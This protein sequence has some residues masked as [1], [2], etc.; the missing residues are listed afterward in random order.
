MATDIA[1]ALG[2][3]K[4]LGERVPAALKL[5][6]LTLA[7]IDDLG[8]IV[9]IAI[10]YSAQ[11]S[12]PALAFG[13][14]ALLVLLALNL[15]SVMRIAPYVVIGIL[16]WVS[17]LKSGVHATLAGVVLALFIPLRASGGSEHSPLREVEHDIHPYV[18]YGILPLFAFANAGISMQG[19]TF[20]ALAHP[21]P[22]GIALG[23]FVGK[24]VGV[25]GFS[26]LAV[27]L[28][29]ATL[30]AG[31]GWRQVHGM[32]I[33]CGVGFTM[34]LFV[35]SLAFEEG[36]PNYSLTNRLGIIAGSVLSGLAGY[37]VLR[38][39]LARRTSEQL[40]MEMD[41]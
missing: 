25:L 7:I 10:F 40:Q 41:L 5:F 38:A 26:W 20:A 9:T 39:T 30:P 21:V 35:A 27:R 23:L 13:C 16:L 12:V 33:L 19:I 28:G 2:I 29:I 8:A 37:F 11:I 34:G 22:V 15:T 4:L 17:V 1:F 14:I 36:G 24:Q 32:A 6:L 18:A 3:L 31:L